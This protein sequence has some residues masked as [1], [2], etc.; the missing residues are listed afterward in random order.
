MPIKIKK[1]KDETKDNPKINLNN[2]KSSK[3]E[4]KKINEEKIKQA[5]NLNNKNIKP[6]I[7][8]TIPSITIKKEKKI[9]QKKDNLSNIL[10]LFCNVKK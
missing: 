5:E 9:E 3:V 6:E 2:N 7:P 8:Q 10:Y 4:I 1:K